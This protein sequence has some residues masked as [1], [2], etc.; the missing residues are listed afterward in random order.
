MRNASTLISIAGGSGTGKSTL[1]YTLLD[2]FPEKFSVVHLDDYFQK[3]ALV[4]VVENMTNWDHPEAIRWDDL[5]RDL[6]TL[7][8]GKSI[9]V[10]TKSERLNP[11]YREKGKKRITVLPNPIIF[12]EGFLALWHPDVRSFFATSVYLATN[13]EKTR[14][15]RRAA[16]RQ[17]FRAKPE[18][19]YDDNAYVEKVLL[20]M[21]EKFLYPTKQFAD[22]VL[23]VTD[24]T[25]EQVADSVQT[26]L[27]PS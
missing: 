26:F 25:S 23:D 7:R 17:Q 24:M 18:K 12:V 1:V 14:L 11:E 13:D 6:T 15:S 4:P 9:E 8:S 3:R 10:M 20:P 5:I 21:H 22:H 19:G 16:N 2:R 27:S